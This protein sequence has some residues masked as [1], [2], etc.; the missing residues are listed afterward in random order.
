MRKL[1]VLC[2]AA[3]VMGAAPLGAEHSFLGFKAFL[4]AD[5]GWSHARVVNESTVNVTS[6]K[7]DLSLVGGNIGLFVGGIHT[8]D[9]NMNVGIE[10]IASWQAAQGRR[11]GSSQPYFME[12]GKQK[13]TFGLN[14]LVGFTCPNMMP[15]VRMG[16]SSSR[17]DVNYSAQAEQGYGGRQVT[18]S[19]FLLGVG[20]DFP[21]AEGVCIGGAFDHTWYGSFTYESDGTQPA[22]M[23]VIPGTDRF[24]MR[25]KFMF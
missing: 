7:S 6:T 13:Q 25:V 3:L 19:G 1:S 4:G 24:T 18:K 11:Q 20:A 9:N 10:G 8:F 14:A 16:W 17:F 2:T 5:G 23:K 12:Y 21:V 15:F 22:Y